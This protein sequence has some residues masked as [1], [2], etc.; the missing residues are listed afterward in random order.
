MDIWL[1]I[2]LHDVMQTVLAID[3]YRCWFMDIKNEL[4]RLE[5]VNQSSPKA[6]AKKKVEL[7]DSVG[8]E[9]LK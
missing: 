6:P 5:L 3:F 7:H 2:G 4:S 9:T 8:C 1:N